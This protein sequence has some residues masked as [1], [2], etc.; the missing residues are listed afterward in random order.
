MSQ[1]TAILGHDLAGGLDTATGLRSSSSFCN[2]TID[3][4]IALPTNA[5]VYCK[6]KVIQIV[7][8]CNRLEHIQRSGSGTDGDPA[9]HVQTEQV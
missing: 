7:K 1:R 3:I 4:F 6:F 2:T 8:A 5:M 9:R